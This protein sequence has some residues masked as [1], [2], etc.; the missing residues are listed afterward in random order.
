MTSWRKLSGS[1]GEGGVPFELISDEE[2]E[3]L[4][5]KTDWPLPTYRGRAHP[6]LSACHWCASG[7]CGECEALGMPFCACWRDDHLEAV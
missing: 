7:R 6:G 2:F 3:D 1:N 5:E 4:Q